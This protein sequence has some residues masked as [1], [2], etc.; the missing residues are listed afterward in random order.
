M[1]LLVR[2]LQ[3]FGLGKPLYSDVS[4]ES[5][6]FIP[7]SDFFTRRYK[8]DQWRSTL[9][10]ANLA[11]IMANRGSYI[12]PHLLRGTIDNSSKEILPQSYERIK[13]PVDQ[14]YF[15]PVIEGMELAV[16]SG[17]ATLAYNDKL[18]ICGKTGTSENPH[19]EDHSVFFAFAPKYNPKIAIAVYVENAGWGGAVAAPIASLMIEKYVTDSIARPSLE[20]YI[21][22]KNLV[23]PRPKISKQ[24]IDTSLQIPLE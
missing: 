22:E 18:S 1:D 9:Q 12:T 24:P 13:V 5:P 19:G 7:T 11:C 4:G 10:M 17:T 3:A 8:T 6:G 2:Y 23:N 14:K 20:K 21:I 16:K 15:N